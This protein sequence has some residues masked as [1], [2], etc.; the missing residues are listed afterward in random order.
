VPSA[1]DPSALPAGDRPTP[2]RDEV[3]VVLVGMLAWAAALVVLAA[4]FHHDLERHDATW[5]LWTC[6]IGLGFGLYGLRV[7][8][9]RRQS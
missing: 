2:P 9:R 5:W 1:E 4:F 6:V 8:L 3:A 7:A